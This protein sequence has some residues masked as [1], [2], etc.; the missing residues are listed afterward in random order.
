MPRGTW[1][2]STREYRKSTA[3]DHRIDLSS[4]MLSVSSATIDKS[5]SASADGMYSL[6]AF[7][8]V[9]MVW[10]SLS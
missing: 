4:K 10:F 6:S 7:R 9:G 1:D 3:T 5:A 8:D 2:D